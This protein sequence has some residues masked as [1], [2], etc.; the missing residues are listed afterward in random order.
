MKNHILHISFIGL[1]T[2][3]LLLHAVTS[4][5]HVDTRLMAGDVVF[6]YQCHDSV[7][8][9]IF[10]INLGDHHLEEFQISTQSVNISPDFLVSYICQFGFVNLS[11]VQ[12]EDYFVVANDR[13]EDLIH[14]TAFSLRGPP[15]LMI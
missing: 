12:S 3:I 8:K 9:D 7:L 4:H 13:G 14:L 15:A 6:S 11:K 10:G 5:H 2:F 1:A